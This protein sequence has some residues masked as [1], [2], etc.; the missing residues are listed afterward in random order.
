M[1]TLVLWL[2]SSVFSYVI[3]IRLLPAVGLDNT[4]FLALSSYIP[5][6]ADQIVAIS[7][8]VGAVFTFG[9]KSVMPQRAPRRQAPQRPAVAQAVP[10]PAAVVNRPTIPPPTLTTEQSLWLERLTV[11]TRTNNIDYKAT[12]LVDIETIKAIRPMAVFLVNDRKFANFTLPIFFDLVDPN[13]VMVYRTMVP[14]LMKMGRNY[15]VPQTSEFPISKSVIQGDWSLR[16]WANHK[17][18]GETHFSIRQA[19]PGTLH[20]FIGAD[21]EIDE[22]GLARANE[23][24]KK[25]TIDDLLR[26]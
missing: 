4:I 12:R 26:A 11:L 5:S 9:L 20:Q 25:F 18:W 22:R 2:L 10:T 8:I 21:L 16:I 1:K 17:S 3:L 19:L 23:V 7:A 14:V 6:Y 24:A 13:G 15:V